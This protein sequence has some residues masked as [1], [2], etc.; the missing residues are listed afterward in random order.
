M[1]RITLLFLLLCSGSSLLAQQGSITLL[2][3][4]GYTFE[5]QVDF[6]NGYG[7]IKD[8]FQWG[9][10]L[11]VGISDENAFELY[12]QQL[13]TEGFVRTY[14]GESE[15]ADIAVSYIM[16]G[17]TRYM[18]I[19]DVLSGFGSLD[20]GLGVLAPESSSV[21]NSTKF[22]W[23]IR[24]G[25]RVKPAEKV[26]LRIH[27][28]LLSPVQAAGGGFYFGTGGAGAGVSTYSSIYQFNLGGSLNFTIK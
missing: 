4:G 3:F 22:A 24:A 28:Q 8:G 6:S 15:A 18:P 1:Y 23:G 13:K 16:L 14:L 9:V 2:T 21:S 20:V 27:A 26:S 19:N 25:L 12:Y 17:G 11:E 7:G 5:D 10:G